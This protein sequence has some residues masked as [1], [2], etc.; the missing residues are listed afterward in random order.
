MQKSRTPLTLGWEAARANAVPALIIQ[1]FMLA[2]LIAYYT[3]H[4][5]AAVVSQLAEYKRSH[6]LLFVIVPSI[7][8]GGL[9]QEL[10]MIIF[11]Q[12]CRAHLRNLRNLIFT[13]PAWRFVGTLV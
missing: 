6:G 7:T 11:F 10:V 1:E 3:S 8:S 13:V 2:L 12:R 4:T 9:I 5:T